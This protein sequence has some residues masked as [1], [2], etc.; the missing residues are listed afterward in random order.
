MGY[1]GGKVTLA[2]PAAQPAA[3]GSDTS[4]ILN[5]VQEIISSQTGYSVDMLEEGLDLEADLGIDTVKQVEIFGLISSEYDLEVPEDLKLSE[6]NTISKIVGYVGGKVTLAAPVAQQAAGADTSGI[7]S[8]V[9][10]IISSQTGYSVDMLEEGLDLEADLG[11]DT[12]KQVEIFGLISSEY[13]LEVPED[14]KLSELNTITKIVGYIGRKVTVAAPAASTGKPGSEQTVSPAA[15]QQS[16]PGTISRFAVEAVKTKMISEEKN[17]FENKTI[18]VSPDKQGFSKKLIAEIEKRKGKAVTIGKGKDHEIKCDFSKLDDVE[19]AVRTVI[20][21]HPEISG[22]I[23]LLPLDN[24]FG[25]RALNENEINTSVK[26]L[27]IMVKGLAEKLNGPGSIISSL[28]FDSVVFPYTGMDADIHP[29]FAGIGGMMKTINKEFKDTFVKMVDFSYNDPKK[30]SGKIID[31]YMRELLSGDTRVETGFHKKEKYVISLKKKSPEKGESLVRTGDT[32]LVTGGAR[33]ITFEILKEV[34]KKNENLSLILLGRSD[35]EAIDSEYLAESADEQFIFKSLK[36]KMKGSKPLEIRKATEKA[37]NIKQTRANLEFLRSR[38]VETIDHS[39]D[40]SN[41]KALADVLKGHE[42]I[43]GIIHAAGVE[44]SNFIPNKELR[45]FNL[46]FD[47][48]IT[49]MMN[50]LEVLK[51]RDYR[52]LIGFSSVAAKFGNEGQIDYS[53]G[54]DMLCKMIIRES[55][56]NGKNVKIFDWTAWKD[57]GMATNETVKKVLIENGV[58]LLPV[59]AGVNFFM[60]ELNDSSAREVLVANTMHEFDPDGIFP[61]GSEKGESSKFPFLGEKLEERDNSVVYSRVLDIKNDRF[62]LHHVIDEV[63]LFLGSTG[64]ETM[65]EAA[66]TLAGESRKVFE[67]TEFEIPYGIKILKGRPRE[68]LVEAEKAPGDKEMFR[69]TITSQFRNTKGEVMGDP[70]FHYRGTYRFTEKE[71]E[72]IKIEIPKL[73]SLEYQ[74]E[75]DDIMYHPQR[76]FMDDLFKTIDDM[77]AFDGKTLLTKFHNR[78]SN[79]YFNH[80]SDPELQTDAILVDGMFQT[81]GLLEFLS[82]D[83]V[84][85]PYRIGSLKF[86]RDVNTNDEYL[87]ITEKSSSDEKTNRYQLKLIDSQ[88]NLFISVEDFEMIRVGKLPGEFQIRDRI[89]IL[90][91]AK[92]N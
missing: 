76:L 17:I 20:E 21:K 13:D 80:I 54:N 42:K 89:R 56:S 37:L 65:A 58:E 55:I 88:G 41:R 77:V 79:K 4:G 30:N 38:G 63:P 1:V 84:V 64:V 86:H 43:D 78:S 23:H 72:E 61:G 5:K 22:F 71:N 66:A 18:L 87:C 47:T 15:G 70:T 8:K 29:L 36:E 25:K 11:I 34:V 26:S 40:V 48:K 60:E 46:V 53:G 10:E 68:I 24:Y 31:L 3:A 51:E 16:G 44:I 52:F 33:G 59:D 50:L 32:L 69:C 14:L 91:D 49:G 39:V 73:P 82:T 45:T 35:I 62:L 27:F 85:L 28:S 67:V 9:Q 19:N 92:V 83:E 7:L 6:L 75:A 81:G 74:G 90:E 2:A 12:V 57:I